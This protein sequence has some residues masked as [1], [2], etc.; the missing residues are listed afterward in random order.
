MLNKEQRVHILKVKHESEKESESMA[1][2]PNKEQRVH[3][4]KV[5]RES[6]K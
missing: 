5:K 6:E 2:I 1:I 3:I 4:L